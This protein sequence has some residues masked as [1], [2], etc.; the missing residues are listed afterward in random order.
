[1]E[2]QSQRIIMQDDTPQKTIEARE[3]K[4]IEAVRQSGMARFSR[5]GNV[6]F[7]CGYDAVIRRWDISEGTPKELEP[8]QGHH[9]WVTSLGV[10]PESD[11][12]FSVDSWG[13]LGARDYAG[14]T[15]AEVWKVEQAHDGWI[16][17]LVLSND[18]NLIAT[19]GR[20]RMLRVWSST[21]GN[22]L[23]ELVGHE[24]EIYSIAI[25][26]HGKSVV[27]GDLKGNVKHWN[28]ETG[29]CDRET[30]FE[31]MYFYDRIQDVAGLQTLLSIDEG[32][33]LLCA[34]AEPT[35]AGRAFGIPTIY[36][37][38]WESLE[39]KKTLNLGPD[40]DGYIF[41]MSWHPD[42][43]LMLV[44]CGPPGASR[45][46]LQRL[47]D[48]MPFYENKKMYNCHSLA[49]HAAT[50]RIVVSATNQNSQGN[51]TVLDKA[52]NYLGNSSPLHLFELANV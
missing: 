26:P 38:D 9:G 36:W 14:E 5:S 32:K 25:H 13:Q 11:L 50:K 45:F 44:T 37:I 2:L 4:V 34:G 41:D 28:L 3:L 52:G 48:E 39:T 30:R 35:R 29:Q 42:G 40:K 15:P 22:L 17:S 24:E 10:H 51:G 21:D 43:F 12:L 47:D 31:K 18:G 7:A 19:G 1:M 49:F 6:L 46:L 27:S 33:T 16:R 23:H 8:L 20:D